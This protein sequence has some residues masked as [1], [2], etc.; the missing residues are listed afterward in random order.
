MLTVGCNKLAVGDNELTVGDNKLTVGDN[1]L[2]VGDNELAVGD[3]H[4][5]LLEVAR[6]RVHIDGPCETLVP[7]SKCWGLVGLLGAGEPRNTSNLAGECN[8]CSP[9]TLVG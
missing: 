1:K 9:V 5:V 7:D 8:Q 3:N 4:N 2:A 6:L